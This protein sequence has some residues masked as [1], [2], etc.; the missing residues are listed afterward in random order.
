MKIM[1]KF[2]FALAVVAA[3]MAAAPDMA[4]AKKKSGRGT[5]GSWSSTDCNSTGCF[6]TY[7]SIDTSGTTGGTSCYTIFIPIVAE[8]PAP[9]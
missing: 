3:A 4:E 8:A 2:S 1:S 5:K 7:C 6:Y 9:L